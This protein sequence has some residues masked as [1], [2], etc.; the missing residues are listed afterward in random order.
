MNLKHHKTL[1][2]RYTV[3]ISGVVSHG[4]VIICVV[5]PHN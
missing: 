5:T 1:G 3:H 2:L 4:S